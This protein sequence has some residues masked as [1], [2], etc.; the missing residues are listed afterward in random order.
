MVCSYSNNTSFV[1]IQYVDTFL[2]IKSI[3]RGCGWKGRLGHGNEDIKITPQLVKSLDGKVIVEVICGQHYTCAITS[4]GSIYTWGTSI[5]AGFGRHRNILLPRL[6][7]DLSIKCVLCVSVNYGITACVTRGGEVF[8]WGSGYGG[9]LGHGDQRDQLTPRRVD[10]LIDVIPKHVSCGRFH[11]AVCT[12]DGKVYIFGDGQCG[13]LGHG[14]KESKN[15]PVLVKALKGKHIT[16]VQCGM[17]HNSMA[18]TSSGYVFT[19]GAGASGLLGR[20]KS[21]LR[22][23][24]IPCLVEGLRQHNI[25]Q[26]ITTYEQCA[27]IVDPI[28][29]PI[30]QSQ[31]ASFNN[32]VNADVVFMVENE[33]LYANVEVLSQK[34]DY[35]AAMFRCNMKESIE[36]IVEIPNCSKIAFLELLKYLILDDFVASLKDVLVLW[37]LAD[38]YQLDGLK[39]SCMGALDRCLCKENALQIYLET[40]KLIC[41]CD[42]LKRMCSHFFGVNELT[43]IR[44]RIK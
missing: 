28:P 43:W 39:Y 3:N 11:T 40:D 36:R 41:P 12:E 6:L 16:Q 34:S 27:V 23:L 32:K 44:N 18:L 4:T 25:V 31:Q 1:Q 17:Y 14:N 26:I 2:E 8:T 24:S 33:P 21:N 29:S 9:R 13:Q 10:T 37:Y 15:Y 5:G 7:G 42:E 35:F 30:R 19:W 38:M 22:D 20:G